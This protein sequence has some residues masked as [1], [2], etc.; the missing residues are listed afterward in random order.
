MPGFASAN[1]FKNRQNATKYSVYEFLLE[2]IQIYKA[3]THH[4]TVPYGGL[5]LPVLGTMIHLHYIPMI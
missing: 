4:N 5:F 3:I 1:Y 2:A